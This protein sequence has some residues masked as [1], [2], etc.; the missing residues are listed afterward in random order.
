MANLLITELKGD[1]LWAIYRFGEYGDGEVIRASGWIPNVF[2]IT[3]ADIV[4]KKYLTDVKV[5]RKIFMEASNGGRSNQKEYVSIEDYFADPSV[6][7]RYFD[8][9]ASSNPMIYSMNNPGDIEHLDL[10]VDLS[11]N[12]RTFTLREIMYDI[13]NSPIDEWY[14]EFHSNHMA[15]KLDVC[16]TFD[17][18]EEAILNQKDTDDLFGKRY[19]PV[20][21]F[22]LNKATLEQAKNVCENFK[23]SSRPIISND[24]CYIGLRSKDYELSNIHE[25]YE[26]GGAILQHQEWNW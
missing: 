12:D 1:K 8:K 18:P 17:T 26:I 15:L 19:F 23:G 3:E 13:S 9:L 11:Y 16:E 7:K 10:I 5:E 22:N 25:I 4:D 6:K 2:G 21:V 14:S 24:R 20:A